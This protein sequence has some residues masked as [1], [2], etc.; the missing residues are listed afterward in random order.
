MHW[1]AAFENAGLQY[2]N[3][4]SFRDTLAQLGERTCPTIEHYKAWS[5]NLGHEHVQ[6]TLTS[7]G[8]IPAYRQGELVRGMS[9]RQSDGEISPEERKVLEQIR[10][11]TRNAA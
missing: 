3:P 8:N 5:Q 2:F 7:Y 9:G 6:T 4:H 10:R 1:L 11:L